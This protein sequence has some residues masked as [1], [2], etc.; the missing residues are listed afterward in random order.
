MAAF[1][2]KIN[3]Y[4][5]EL[6]FDRPKKA[7]AL[8]AEGWRELRQHFEALS[9]NSAVRV[10]ILSG[11]G[12]HWCAGIDLELLM[13]LA[14]LGNIDC[15]AR[16]RE[17]IRAFIKEL[18][19]CI[20]AVER[21]QQ[22]VLAAIQ[23]GC[24]GGGLDI[25]TA[26]DMRYCTEDAYFCVK[27]IDLGLV[28]DL[29]TLQRLPGIIPSGIAAE[30]AFTAR[31]VHSTEAQ[32]IGLVNRSYSDTNS[33]REG[34][35]AIAQKMA[36]KSPLVTRGIKEVLRYST[37]HSIAEGLDYVANY[38]AAFLLSNDLMAAFAA[39]LNKSKPTFEE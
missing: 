15:E 19:N 16:K 32:R 10:I 13:G 28:A 39:N 37:N 4:I 3:N 11:A 26:C 31:N 30:M 8:N 2:L 33:L 35:W 38:N 6:R 9:H 27:E 1:Q 14:E 5:A 25:A 29:G 22:P 17:Q 20:N 24:I 34:V 7:N 18:Q 23:G 21:C 36:E 12:K